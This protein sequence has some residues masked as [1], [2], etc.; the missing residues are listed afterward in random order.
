MWFKRLI[1]SLSSFLFLFFILYLLVMLW[2]LALPVILF[3]AFLSWWRARQIHQLFNAMMND[4]PVKVRPA[5]T[6]IDDNIIDADFEEIKE[7]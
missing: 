5:K 7:K 2:W 1:V 4:P 3:F 6:I